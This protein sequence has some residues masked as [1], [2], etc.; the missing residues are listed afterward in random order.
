MINFRFMWDLCPQPSTV[1]H[2]L[3]KIVWRNHLECCGGVGRRNMFWDDYLLLEAVLE[4]KSGKL[5]IAVFHIV[6]LLLLV[7]AP[8]IAVAPQMA[9]TWSI[10]HEFCQ[11]CGIKSL[12]L[13]KTI[14]KKSIQQSKHPHRNPI[15]LLSKAENPK[16]FCF[17]K[18]KTGIE[19]LFNSFQIVLQA[20]K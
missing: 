14:S 5:A 19:T 18:H 6:Y 8:K 16:I 13:E 7:G 11:N 1:Q 2:K 4:F 17:P 12:N 3:L 9:V 15:F 10:I 20:K